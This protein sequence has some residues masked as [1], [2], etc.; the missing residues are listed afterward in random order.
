MATLSLK[1]KPVVHRLVL[2]S[3]DPWRPYVWYKGINDSIIAF[4]IQGWGSAALPKTSDPTLLGVCGALGEPA[5]VASVPLRLTHEP[6]PLVTL[7]WRKQVVYKNR[8]TETGQVLW[9]PIPPSHIKPE[10]DVSDDEE[11]D[12]DESIGNC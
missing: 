12:E 4:N 1:R 7:D 2:D 8:D 11:T 5:G 3:F 9:L 10:E 6:Q